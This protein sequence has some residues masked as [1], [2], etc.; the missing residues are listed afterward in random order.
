MVII[1]VYTFAKITYEANEVTNGDG[2]CGGIN[3]EGPVRG[4]RLLQ[5]WEIMSL[6]GLR[7]M[8][9]GGL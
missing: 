7:D 2:G 3:L 5:V 6:G 8:E 1:Q 4:C 9:R